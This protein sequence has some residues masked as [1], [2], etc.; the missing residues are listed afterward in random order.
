MITQE[1]NSIS[2]LNLAWNGLHVEGCRALTDVL[3]TASTLT[4]LDLSCNRIN[5][6]GLKYLLD[7]LKKNC[8]ISVLKVGGF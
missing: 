2:T 6:L 1:N 3:A 4:Y 7:G 8:S 5:C